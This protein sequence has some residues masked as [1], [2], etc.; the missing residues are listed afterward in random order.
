MVQSLISALPG[1][2]DNCFIHVRGSTLATKSHY[3]FSLLRYPEV[4]DPSKPFPGRSILDLGFTCLNGHTFYY[5]YVEFK[6]SMDHEVG[7]APLMETIR[8]VLETYKGSSTAYDLLTSQVF[9]LTRAFMNDTLC[10]GAMVEALFGLAN[11]N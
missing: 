4:K 6:A 2:E 1:H 5:S 8:S 7:T 9:V 11:S 10:T 3:T